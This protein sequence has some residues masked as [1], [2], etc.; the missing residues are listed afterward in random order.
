MESTYS[1]RLKSV[2]FRAR[3]AARRSLSHEVRTEH[4][5]LGILE[6]G[7]GGAVNL[8]RRLG[9]EL[10]P[11]REKAEKA[12]ALTA[13]PGGPR[14][15]EI[16]LSGR[17]KGVLDL[18][19]HEAHQLDQY[20]VGTEH[21]LLA[22]TKEGEGG[23]AIILAEL[24]VDH[25][26]VTDELLS[27]LG[28]SLLPEH[29]VTPMLDK[30]G[31]DL[32]RLAREGRLDPVIER[33]EEIE[34]L[35]RILLRR[36]KNN[37][38]L[39]GGPG[40][41]KTSVV[42][43]LAHLIARG[44]FP[45]LLQR[46]R[47]VSLDM[48]FLV[49]EAADRRHVASDLCTIL[50][51]IRGSRNSIPFI[52][53]GGGW[54]IGPSQELKTAI[55]RGELQC[56]ATMSPEEYKGI[57]ETDHVLERFF[58]KVAVDA[59]ARDQ[60]ILIVKGL[61]EKYEERHQ[62][63]YPD[64]TLALAVDLVRLRFP[65]HPPLHTV[66][67][68]IERAAHQRTSAQAFGPLE[69]RELKRRIDELSEKRRG[70]EVGQDYEKV[71]TLRRDEKRLWM[72]YLS[73]KA[74]WRAGADAVPFVVGETEIQAAVDELSERAF[75]SGE[76]NGAPAFPGGPS[77]SI[78]GERA[79][80]LEQRRMNAVLPGSEVKIRP[81]HALVLIPRFLAVERKLEREEA[82]GLGLARGWG[83]VSEPQDG[84]GIYEAAILPALEGSGLFVTKVEEIG[85]LGESLG[86]LWFAIRSAEV[87]V[88]DVTGLY[89]EVLYALG[90]CHGLKRCPILLVRSPGD[91]PFHLIKLRHIRYVDSEEGAMKL[92]RTLEN[93]VQEVLS[94]G[95]RGQVFSVPSCP[96]V[97][98]SLS[99]LTVSKGWIGCSA[100]MLPPSSRR[101]FP[102]STRGCVPPS[103]A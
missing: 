61:R 81:G 28:T 13:G 55:A 35:V 47:I 16:P 8:L 98:E 74:E 26:R 89:P 73:A 4:L 56:I 6:E 67:Q 82:R 63:K 2:L 54:G 87:I 75:S 103:E 19:G 62:A 23:A 50:S 38:I 102:R 43:G 76:Y 20:R 41:G 3:W 42:H 18:A 94:G 45:E 21:L 99:S 90:L 64:A 10:G 88:A 15:D 29:P 72:E 86:N 48:P 34:R 33:D 37:P 59:P 46:R 52:D 32:T 69:L 7:E 68:V 27:L 24:G 1:K 93:V 57:V 51:E 83:V 39:V 84:R 36:T 85:G 78:S 44:R 60:T 58:E 100:V 30:Y 71:L 66:L 9:A 40:V 22:L 31:E 25:D 11:L 5:L 65:D 14:F 97:A 17:V 92:K 91:V 77:S 96:A 70:A 95:V 101:W 79:R 12:A 80:L 49:V 53:I